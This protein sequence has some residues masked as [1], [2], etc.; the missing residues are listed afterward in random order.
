MPLH[1]Y[2]S[3]RLEILAEQLAEQLKNAPFTPLQEEIIVVQSRGMER[4]LSL[5]IARRHGICANIAF[6]FPNNIL[7][8]TICRILPDIPDT[9]PFEPDVLKWRIMHLLDGDRF[10]NILSYLSGNSGIKRFQIAERIA[11]MFDQYLVFRPDVMRHW[12]N[13]SLQHQGNDEE[14]WQSELWRML[15]NDTDTLHKAALLEKFLRII[16]TSDNAAAV[17]P[18]RI[19][20]FGISVL[21][22]FHVTFFTALA[23]RIEVNLFLM[24]PCREYWGDILS[25]RQEYKLTGK[26]PNTLIAAEELHFE[27]GNSL[28]ASLGM[29]GIEFFDRMIAAGGNQYELFEDVQQESLLTCIQSDI[30]TLRD[31][32]AGG[33][34]KTEIS[35]DDPSIQIHSCHSPMREIEVLY[36]TL[37]DLLDRDPELSPHDILVMTPDINSYAPI[38]EAVFNTPEQENMRIPFSIADRS[39]LS[40]T[41]LCNTFLMLLDL[42]RSRF[43]VSRVMPILESP[44]VGRKFNL[45]QSDINRIHTWISKTRIRWG[46]DETTGQ[47]LGLPGCRENTWMAGMERL[48]LGYAMPGQNE[49]MFSGIL[50]YDDIEGENARVLGKFIE[51]TNNIFSLAAGLAQPRPL[52]QWAG[53]LADILETF[54]HQD[55]ENE[56]TI[57]AVRGMFAELAL[58]QTSSGFSREVGLDVIKD[59]VKKLF[60]RETIT[61]GFVT[62]A[63]TFCAMLPMRSIP[64]NVICLVGMNDGAYPRRSHEPSFN[65]INRY[66]RACDRS[67]KKDDR[68]LFLE[69]I[70]S[71]RS[72][73]AI[74][75]TGQNIQDNSVIP[76]SVV[77][78]ELIDYLEQGFFVAGSTVGE[79]IIRKH[80]LQAFSCRYFSGNEKLFSYSQE[81]CSCAGAI[82]QPRRTPAPFISRP[83]SAQDA[84]DNSVALHDVIAFYCSPAEFFLRKRLGIVLESKEAILDDSENFTI[85]GL[86]RYEFEQDMLEKQLSRKDSREMYRLTKSLGIL[87]HGGVGEYVFSRTHKQVADFVSAVSEHTT[88]EASTSAAVELTIDQ[89]RLTGH[90][91]GVRPSGLLVYRYAVLRPKDFLSLWIEHLA[92]T[93]MQQ[94]NLP[95]RSVLVGIK[96]KKNRVP[97]QWRY[98]AA[99]HAPDC[100]RRLLTLYREGLT[101]PIAFFPKASLRFAEAVVVKGTSTE[102][103]LAGARQDLYGNDYARGELEDPYCSLCFNSEE[104]PWDEFA[105]CSLQVYEPLLQHRENVES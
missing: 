49:G 6:P 35:G 101:R 38:I 69:A 83:L 74:S 67:P 27:R 20:V 58:W 26:Y 81:N 54:F 53:I 86:D 25:D 65:L 102:A 94:D 84:T 57:G 40:Q 36:E 18:P 37:L 59:Q 45:T 104:I 10:Q 92:I 93:M 64:F 21:P 97:V 48:L 1:V 98:V 39:M 99:P 56:Q 73:L 50:P 71:A 24:N 22:P 32:G 68:Y 28:L 23:S 29:H 103:A 96:D 95:T 8:Q 15:C 85:A 30:L 14:Q 82:T 76:P 3:N 70:L 87:P 34:A 4:W 79:T 78:S 100:V 19:N 60:E 90:V 11:H 46:I 12:E 2:T 75:Y 77:V 72:R 91:E 62:G 5:E 80:P 88:Q 43:E 66:P 33:S 61:T 42:C 9:R 16:E 41:G 105:H 17:L 7:T 51:F 13:G 31:R 89:T 55:T 47:E 63:V 44:A 52:A